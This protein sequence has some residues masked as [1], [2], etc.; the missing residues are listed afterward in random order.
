MKPDAFSAE[1]RTARAAA[2]AAAEII[3]AYAQGK[4]DS[5][6]K[7]EDN[8]VTQADLDANQA[9]IS[10]IAAAFPRDAI[11][12]EETAD[13]GERLDCERVWV[14]D[15]L[16]G[17]KEF[18]AGIPEYAV[19]VALT[20]NGEPMVGVVHQPQ[21]AE[22]FWAAKGRGAWLNEERIRISEAT[23]FDQ[24]V[25]LSSRSEMKRGQVDEYKS[26]FREVRPVGSVA[27]KLAFTAAGRGDVWLSMAPKSEWDVCGGDLLVREAGGTFVT[28]GDGERVYNQKNILLTPIMA[29]GP[30]E[31]IRAMRARTERNEKSE[32]KAGA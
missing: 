12:S 30:P 20:V 14:I 29:A 31:L 2:E 10:R 4:R 7:T 13:S 24:A 5:W 21:T 25:M 11:L 32:R 19:S 3:S 16:D 6:D 9:I 1:L 22:C 18:I 23:D 28:F 15:P 17:T 8:P 26:W 27:L